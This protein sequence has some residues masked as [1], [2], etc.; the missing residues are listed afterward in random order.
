MIETNI[1]ILT[2]G[3]DFYLNTRV[4]KV[5]AQDLSHDLLGKTCNALRYQ[6]GLAAVP[7]LTSGEILV[8]SQ[9]QLEPLVIKG[10]D[11]RVEVRDGGSTRRLCFSESDNRLAL[12]RLVER[13]LLMEIQRHMNLWRLSDSLRI[14]YEPEPFLTDTHFAA[15]RRYEASVIPIESV[16]MGLIIDPSTTFFTI[17]SVADFF[18][19]DLSKGEQKQRQD[20]F[21]Y[22]T[23]RQK[24]R[25][26]TLLY[27]LGKNKRSKC[28]FVDFLPGVTC[29]TTSTL[30]VEGRDY[31]SLFAYYQEKQP[32]LDVKPG[33]PVAKVS[34]SN[35]GRPVPVAANKLHLRVTNQALPEDL[36]QTHTIVPHERAKYIEDFWTR[37]GDYP[38]G[39]GRP[40]VERRFWQPSNEQSQLLR[41]PAIV[42]PGKVVHAPENA[43][44]QEQR[45]YFSVRR[46]LLRKLGC[47]E[48]PAVLQRDVYFA[49]PQQIDEE[50]ESQLTD[51]V[52]QYLSTWTKKEIKAQPLPYTNLEDA[53]TQLHKQPPGVVVFVFDDEDPA[54]YFQVT[55]ELKEWRV[56][57][58]IRNTLKTKFDG[59]KLAEKESPSADGNI[60]RP[61]R[62]W[63]SFTE[64][65]ALD[66]LQQLECIPWVVASTLHYDARLAID[67]GEDQ[68]HFSLTLLICRPKTRLP[69]FWV[70][71][72]VEI[73]SDPKSETINERQLHDKIIAL[74][75]H[76]PLRQFVAISSLLVERDGHECGDELIAIENAKAELIKLGYLD[77]K[78][79]VD[80][81]DVHKQS[82]KSIRIWDR[83]E[84]NIVRH[85]PEGTAVFLDRHTVVLTNTG[86]ATLHQGTAE[87]IMLVAQGDSVDMTAVATAIHATSHL[88]WSSPGVS[89]RLPLELKRTDE[90]L[91]KRGAQEIRLYK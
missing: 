69:S 10:D 18:R 48:T 4:A 31:P 24:E 54:A 2:P 67:V 46:R 23:L 1:R 27:D 56:K 51:D 81:V 57:H 25:K 74:F 16:G 64:M 37:L 33:D 72:V 34:F 30:T 36:K 14:W 91:E 89:Q 79:K 44:V 62:D 90:E 58:V 87:P 9:D 80:V 22:L 82:V 11:W 12:S 78:V 47:L 39:L 19:A 75:K 5:L 32:H 76:L 41:Q 35:I 60:P 59:F 6:H 88:N 65:T 42:F 53:I 45:E 66:V 50:M 85:A 52:T 68:R 20:L 8:A 43:D 84:N 61:V 7:S 71:T 49:L 40:K 83:D 28:Y 17:P 13:L 3:S 77:A 15:Y 26:G 29:A 86:A 73:K 55:H 21:R 38:L 70:D 63:Q